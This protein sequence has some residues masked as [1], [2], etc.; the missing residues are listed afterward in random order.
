[1]LSRILNRHKYVYD[2]FKE[3]YLIGTDFQDAFQ[4]SKWKNI[5]VHVEKIRGLLSSLGDYVLMVEQRL[6]NY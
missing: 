2:S 1:M 5:R 4:K 3:N 6:A